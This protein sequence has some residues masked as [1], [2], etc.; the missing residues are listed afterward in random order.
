M[1]EKLQKRVCRVVGPTLDASYETLAYCKVASL[2]LFYR[3]LAKLT[4]LPYS[5][6]RSTHYS[7]T[8]HDLIPRCWGFMGGRNLKI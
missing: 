5:R 6:V 2:T 1:S 3:H 8:L 7:N 4:P